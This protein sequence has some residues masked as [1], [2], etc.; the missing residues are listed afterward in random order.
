[1]HDFLEKSKFINDSFYTLTFLIQD[2]TNLMTIL[3]ALSSLIFSNLINF[4]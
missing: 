2:L 3:S 1:M 4:L